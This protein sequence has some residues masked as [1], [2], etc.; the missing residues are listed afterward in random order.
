MESE[1]IS[2]LSSETEKNK[3]EDTFFIL[4]FAFSAGAFSRTR[5]E[6]YL[7]LFAWFLWKSVFCFPLRS[8]VLPPE[9]AKNKNRHFFS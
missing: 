6:G 9:K 7:S 2:L 8:Y 1:Q 3:P 4:L 5:S